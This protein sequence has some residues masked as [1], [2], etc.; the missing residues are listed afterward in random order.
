MNVFTQLAGPL[1]TIFESIFPSSL[2]K[3]VSN[4]YREFL[5]SDIV[6]LENVQCQCKPPPG[7][8]GSTLLL[9][10]LRSNLNSGHCFSFQHVSSL[11]KFPPD[12]NGLFHCLTPF[13]SLAEATSP[14]WRS[15]FAKA[16]NSNLLFILPVTTISDTSYTERCFSLLFCFLLWAGGL[17]TLPFFGSICSAN[18]GW[19]RDST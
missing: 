12:W 9:T 19:F 5:S 13:V 3:K 15:S 4:T 1:I 8:L 18:L 6:V 14:F 17:L 2:L 11:F 10:T 16:T 7:A